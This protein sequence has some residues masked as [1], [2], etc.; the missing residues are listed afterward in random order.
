VVLYYCR[1]HFA[2]VGPLFYFVS[3]FIFWL[4]VS[5][6]SRIDLDIMLLQILGVIGIIFIL[7]IIYSLY[8]KIKLIVNN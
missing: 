1:T 4:C 3:S 5:L 8:K 6:M 2:L 7:Y